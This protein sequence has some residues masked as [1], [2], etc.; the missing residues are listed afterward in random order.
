MEKHWNLYI[1]EHVQF[2]E[3]LKLLSECMNIK[4]EH[5]LMISKLM[6]SFIVFFQKN[7]VISKEPPN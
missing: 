5:H 4:N 2:S 7:K 1:V 6:A 3:I